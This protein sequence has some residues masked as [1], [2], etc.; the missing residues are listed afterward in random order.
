VREQ[1]LYMGEIRNSTSLKS[2]VLNRQ[3]TISL[4]LLALIL[5]PLIAA[6]IFLSIINTR[7]SSLQDKIVRLEACEIVYSE[8]INKDI[9]FLINKRILDLEEELQ[10]HIQK[11]IY[12]LPH[13]EGA[14]AEFDKIYTELKALKVLVDYK[15]ANRWTRPD[16]KVFMIEYSKANNLK[17]PQHKKITDN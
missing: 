1:D 6:I 17:M 11:G 8:L 16:D 3:T 15:A 2:S 7:I 4:G 9:L 13:P 14:E 12:K 5:S 10:K